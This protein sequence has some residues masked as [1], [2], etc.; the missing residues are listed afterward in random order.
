M[1]TA[2]PVCSPRTLVCFC[3]RVYFSSAR[4][5]DVAAVSP[6]SRRVAAMMLLSVK[7]SVSWECDREDAQ[8]KTISGVQA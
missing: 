7:E 8:L 3:P 4:V 1:H 5:V 6:L 2:L